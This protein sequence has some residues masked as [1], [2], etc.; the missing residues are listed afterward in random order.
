MQS[1]N[2]S[3]RY[4]AASFFWPSLYKPCILIYCY[5]HV[6]VQGAGQPPPSHLVHHQELA[7]NQLVGGANWRPLIGSPL[8][9][10][11]EPPTSHLTRLGPGVGSSWSGPIN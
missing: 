6:L 11:Q 7:V 3:K 10:Y 9:S 4:G 2:F 1:V 8:C 5:M